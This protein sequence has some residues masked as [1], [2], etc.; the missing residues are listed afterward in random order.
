MLCRKAGI[1]ITTTSKEVHNA[2]EKYSPKD[3]DDDN[4]VVFI[5]LV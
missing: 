2:V 1:P 5:Y 3:N 4:T